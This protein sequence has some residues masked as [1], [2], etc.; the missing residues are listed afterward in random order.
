M[1]TISMPNLDDDERIDRRTVLARGG[2]ALSATGLFAATSAS[3]GGSGSQ[4]EATEKQVRDFLRPLLLAAEDVDLWFKRQEFPFCKYDAELGYLHIDRDFQEGLDGAVCRYRYDKFD[5]RR[6]FAHNGEPCRI[7]TYGD[8]FT[9]C[10]QVSDGETWQEALA[11]HLGEPVRNFGIGG[12]SV[13][14][15]YLRMLREEQR[16]PA[17][18]IIFN[19][20]DDDH[21]R[22]L[23]GWQRLKFG[24]NRKSPNPTVP[25]VTVDLD[26]GTITDRPNPCPTVQSVKDLSDLERVY[27][28]FHDDFYLH[29]RLAWAARKARGEPVPPTDYDDQRLIKHGIFASTRIID[30][31]N[32]FA[33]K[34]GK[35]VLY[36]LSYGAYTIRQFIEKGVRFDQALVDYLNEAKL[37]YVDLM[38]AHATDAAGFK[39]T[40]D[41]ALSRYFI[42]HYNPLGNDFCA[43]AMKDPLVKMLDPRPPAYSR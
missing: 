41:E 40:P 11:A 42:G 10:E 28:L 39:G 9:S 5:A 13:Y 3:A 36:V 29:N 1:G 33:K 43:F 31:V 32:E 20:F 22:N 19:I 34:N 38:Q 17:R 4:P 6:M 12:Y 23:H 21:A 27:S 24:V 8:S 15:A 25:H 14:Q 7:N 16:A 26:K 35:Q 2:A 37:P 30:R 18:C